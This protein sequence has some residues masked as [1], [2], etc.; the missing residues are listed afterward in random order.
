MTAMNQA[1]CDSRKQSKCSWLDW[2]GQPMIYDG[3]WF[4]NRTLEELKYHNARVE[5][6]G[7]PGCFKN[8]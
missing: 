2:I 7:R 3:G 8:S 4:V 5:G 1:F 6:T